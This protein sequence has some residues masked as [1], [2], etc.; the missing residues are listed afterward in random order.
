M[1]E[2]DSHENN[3]VSV[4]HFK[5]A[6]I[7]LWDDIKGSFCLA[8]WKDSLIP[9]SPQNA[10]VTQF[11][12][13]QK[14]QSNQLW[15]KNI[16]DIFIKRR[17]AA[18]GTPS[19][20]TLHQLDVMSTPCNEGW[21]SFSI[22]LL[23]FFSLSFHRQPGKR[24]QMAAPPRG[25]H[26]EQQAELVVDAHLILIS[27]SFQLRIPSGGRRTAEQHDA[28]PMGAES[29]ASSSLRMRR[30]RTNDRPNWAIYCQR[31][32]GAA[33]LKRAVTS[34]SL[35]SSAGAQQHLSMGQWCKKCVCVRVCVC[36]R[37]N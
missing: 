23:F 34:S 3:R 31:R 5:E 7:Q 1:R 12:G 24:T 29:G 20:V 36:V 2:N 4:C 27:S 9:P 16:F 26:T 37:A 10:V 15:G 18:T 17:G 32:L 22:I 6:E 21:D 28:A 8:L 25:R 14:C 13:M 11:G 35:C 33:D 19:F 30:R